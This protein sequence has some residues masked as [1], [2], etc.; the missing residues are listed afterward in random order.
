M[1]AQDQLTEDTRRTREIIENSPDS[2]RRYQREVVLFEQRAEAAL[3]LHAGT[4][5]GLRAQSAPDT[6]GARRARRLW[7]FHAYQYVEKINPAP[8]EY[9][10]DDSP[11]VPTNPVA[12]SAMNTDE[13]TAA[14]DVE[15]VIDTDH[16][17]TFTQELRDVLR[18]RRTAG[19][20][21]LALFLTWWIIVFLLSS[22]P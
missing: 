12:L 8:A 15:A 11:W 7:L 18:N 9:L 1:N 3:F 17:K 22:A 20:I 5:A 10:E 4:M 6:D 14:D 16:A 2:R 19:A 13:V 21:L